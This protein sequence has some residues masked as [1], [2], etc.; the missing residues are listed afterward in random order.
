MGVWGE[1]TW[2]LATKV[3]QLVFRVC[4]WRIRTLHLSLVV[5]NN[6]GVVLKEQKDTLLP[7][8]GLALANNDSGPDLLPELGLSLL[9]GSH[10]HVTKASSGQTVQTTVDALQR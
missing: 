1:E 7:A 2:W 3:E 8:P 5:D 10:D 9:H 6:T 4:V